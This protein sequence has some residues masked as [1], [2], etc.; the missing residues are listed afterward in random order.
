MREKTQHELDHKFFQWLSPSYW[1]VEGQ[2]QAVINQRLEGTLPWVLKM[3]EFESWQKSEPDSHEHV[4]WIRGGP[5]MGKSV[6]AG[7]LIEHL[8]MSFPN[9]IVTYFFCKKG[10]AKLTDVRDI[11]R[12]IAYQCLV[13]SQQAKMV[14]ETLK[15]NQFPVTSNCPVRQLFAQ[16]IHEPFKHVTED[17]Y[18]ILDGLD[19][20]NTTTIDTKEMK[21]EMNI[22]IDCLR[23]LKSER[24]VF[25]SR[26]EALLHEVILDPLMKVVSF[27]DNRADIEIYVRR[28]FSKSKKLQKWYPETYGDPVEY[29][30]NHSEGLFLWVF[31]VL[32]Q[33]S[34]ATSKLK[35]K[36]SLLAFSKSSGRMD[37]LYSEILSRIQEDD[38]IWVREVLQWVIAAQRSLEVEELKAAV[39]W[40]LDGDEREDFK[41]FLEVE[42]G[43]LVRFIPGFQGGETIEL[44]HET[45]R[46]F[47]LDPQ[48]APERWLIDEEMIHGHVMLECLRSMSY[49]DQSTLLNRYVAMHWVGHLSRATSIQHCH[50]ILSSLHRFFMSSA[51]TVW[52]SA[53]LS[54]I[55]RVTLGLAIDIEEKY[56]KEIKMWIANSQGSF[57]RTIEIEKQKLTRDGA[58]LAASCEWSQA[59]LCEEQRLGVY[60][61]KAATKVWLYNDDANANADEIARTFLLGLKYYLIE[62]KRT[63]RDFDKIEEL[64][65]DQFINMSAWA[66]KDERRPIQIA[67]LG[68]A[69]HA[70]GK[71]DNCI[72]CLKQQ[73]DAK[74]MQFKF[75]TLLGDAYK[76]KG[77]Y[78]A[79]INMFKVALDK[80]PTEW[81]LWNWLWGAYKLK[82][83][84]DAA[85]NTFKAALDKNP[86]EWSL[87]NR[88]GDAHN[89]KGD[90]NAAIETFKFGID[91][92]PTVWW[93]WE[94]LGDSHK[95]K[96]DYD[97][98]IE[99]FKVGLDKNPTVWQLWEKLGDAY[100]EKGDYDA[101][102]DTFKVAL[103]KNPTEW[104]LW[105]GLGKAY[106]SK[107][108]CDTAI[109]TFKVGLDKHPS[110]ELW[111]GD[112]LLWG[113]LGDAYKTKGDYDAAI[114]T[115][116][117]ALDKHP[118]ASWL[119]EKLGDIYQS[120]GD[121]DVAI[122]TFKV[123]LDKN[124]TYGPLWSGLGNAYKS[125]GDYDAAI[126]TFKVA[127]DKHPTASWPWEKLGDVYQS[128][129]DYNAAIEAF[130]VALDKDPS[131]SWLWNKLSNA[132]KSKG[133]DDAA[134]E[135]FKAG[136]NK[137]PTNW[138]L[139]IGLGDLYKTKGDYDAATET[140]TVGLDKNP[141]VW[142]LSKGL[143]EAY[144]AKGEYNAATET[145]KVA[146]DKN[147]TVWQLSEGL[148]E[149]YKAKGDYDAA[150][151]TFKAALDKNPTEWSLWNRLGDAHKS[152][153]D[154]DAAIE[155]FKVGID[156][157]PTV[158]QLWEGLGD[159]HKAKGDYNA[160]IETFKVGLDK[161]PTVRELWKKLGDTYKLKGDYDAAIETFK[162][163]LDKNP[164][165]WWLWEKLGDAYKS[166]CDYDEAIKVFKAALDKN[167]ANFQLRNGLGE[168]YKAKGD[169]D[170]AIDAFKVAIDKNPVRIY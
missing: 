58:K 170:R 74:P 114:E 7:F 105:E 131:F 119:W 28:E 90:Y 116:E 68:V 76:V 27:V 145:F 19:E 60:V 151:N 99:T 118:T 87:W 153:G 91:K 65:D 120:K 93:L 96:G 135:T 42:C 73:A 9:S 59:I 82:G 1:E 149:A 83:D 37:E 100:K 150:I 108:D 88:L 89:S 164:T 77:N 56:L 66:G 34:A 134:I 84:Y 154:Y 152:K 141:T 3:P 80:N 16:L 79:A 26:P 14:L 92:N 62:D 160:A 8:K 107:G 36:D 98:A 106:K 47:L 165:A 159:S 10:E 72:E 13:R 55:R 144:K 17:V 97:A 2:L 112:A 121:Y 31:T 78:D 133:D 38:Q 110:G 142:Y 52:I 71:W 129:G 69:F 11:L 166:K 104:W 157:N 43:S 163:G 41:T 12:T 139:W 35:F 109:E 161:N 168:A 146:L 5:G 85:I 138:S 32:H 49:G 103:D 124:P 81:W 50:D 45:L 132:Y 54:K 113:D 167:P 156:K 158:W 117:V 136:L 115:F 57:G 122:E 123:G 70:L 24:I 101:A 126:E 40:S 125:K 64:S 94:G 128:K 22:F 130:K 86:T 102:I 48:K 33:L 30:V 143:G 44:I 18:I 67:N 137:N 46:S 63:L 75:G 6:L 21:T 29:F 15:R 20:A 4:L 147:P 53:G 140:F 61:G 162:V 25:I 23:S 148:G 95:A 111:V 127:L 169:Y 155:T 39:E 51:V